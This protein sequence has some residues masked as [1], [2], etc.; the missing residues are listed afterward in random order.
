MFKIIGVWFGLFWGWGFVLFFRLCL[1]FKKMKLFICPI[2][3][4]SLPECSVD[5][6]MYLVLENNFFSERWFLNFFFPP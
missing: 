6:R 1:L 5:D 3:T 2:I 4:G